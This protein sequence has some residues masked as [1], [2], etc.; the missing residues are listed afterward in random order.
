MCWLSMRG[1]EELRGGQGDVD[2][3][4]AVLLV[5]ADVFGLELAEIDASD[6]L[7]VDDEEDA[8]SGEQVGQDGAR[9]GAFDDG[10]DGVDDGFET[11]EPLDAL[12]DGR[13]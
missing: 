11:V 8:V 2:G 1:D 3:A 5:D 10:V 7:A 4:G 12:D 6:G 9:F 13:D